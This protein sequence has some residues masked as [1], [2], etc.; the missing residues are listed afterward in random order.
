M[1]ED[2]SRC[3]LLLVNTNLIDRQPDGGG[4]ASALC[5]WLETNDKCVS[6]RR[7]AHLNPEVSMI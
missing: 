2:G 7:L 3:I 6:G 4:Q 5:C 1:D